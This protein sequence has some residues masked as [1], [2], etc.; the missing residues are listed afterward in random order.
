MD[1]LKLRTVLDGHERIRHLL[2]ANN[3]AVLFNVNGLEALKVMDNEPLREE[4]TA[5]FDVKQAEIG[6]RRQ[7]HLLQ[8][9]SV[10]SSAC[11]P[12]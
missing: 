5:L 11:N 2:R 4:E 1:G 8:L 7:V 12:Q 3:T 9:H 6:E 10:S